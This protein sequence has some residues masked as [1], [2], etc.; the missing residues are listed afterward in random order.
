MAVSKN[1]RKNFYKKKPKKV[2]RME[3]INRLLKDSRH[4]YSVIRNDAIKTIEKLSHI[5]THVNSNDWASDTPE[6]VKKRV[7]EMTNSINDALV[8]GKEVV[9]NTETEYRELSARISAHNIDRSAPLNK[10]DANWDCI[11]LTSN[12]I[13]VQEELTGHIANMQKVIEACIA[14]N[15]NPKLAYENFDLAI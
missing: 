1:K 4:H 3:K 12:I 14:Y 7:I 5:V 13:S 11:T 8:H 2:T 15:T 9:D 10:E 6:E